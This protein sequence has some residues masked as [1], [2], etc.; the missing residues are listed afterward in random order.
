MN[1]SK[2]HNKRFQGTTLIEVLLYTA[3][4]ASLL[5]VVS[6][7]FATAVRIRVENSTILDVQQQAS[8][9]SK[10]IEKE[11]LDSENVILPAVGTSSN[12]LVL[13]T[14]NNT[15]NSSI[16]V[17]SGLVQITKNGFTPLAMSSNKLIV[18]DLTFANSGDGTNPEIITYS[19]TISRINPDNIPELNYSQTYQKSVTIRR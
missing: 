1:T 15:I 8:F 19:F 9:I 13:N 7:G 14:D 10:S 17:S 6:A 2:I 5:L 18:S 4:T 11:I 12:S 16:E 3:L